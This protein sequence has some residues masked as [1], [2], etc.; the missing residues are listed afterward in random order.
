LALTF[1]PSTAVPGT[2][3]DPYVWDTDQWLAI[4]LTGAVCRGLLAEIHEALEAY[5]GVADRDPQRARVDVADPLVLTLLGLVAEQRIASPAR[6]F[7]LLQ[8]LGAQ[9]Y[10]LDAGRQRIE[11]LLYWTN[12]CGKSQVLLEAAEAQTLGGRLRRAVEAWLHGLGV[13]VREEDTVVQA[14]YRL[15]IPH[16]KQADVLLRADQAKNPGK[17]HRVP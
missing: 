14:V 8:C 9:L 12:L 10:R 4:E 16:M 13:D 5:W 6:G 2:D 1:L 17:A 7:H 11:P 3:F 15:S